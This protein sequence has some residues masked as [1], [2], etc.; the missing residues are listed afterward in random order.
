LHYHKKQLLLLL[1]AYYTKLLVKIK[2][3]EKI[4]K[5]KVLEFN[6]PK[7]ESAVIRTVL[8]EEG[9][10]MTSVCGEDIVAATRREQPDVI[11]VNVSPEWEKSVKRIRSDIRYVYT[12][13]FVL[14]EKPSDVNQKDG[15]ELGI[16]GTL[17]RPIDPDRL[18]DMLRRGNSDT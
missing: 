16:K 15:I 3:Q 4:Q 5:T 6:V 12:P 9:Y 13:I 11:L 7:T 17:S 10:E 2:K 14:T 18:L 8:E 1:P